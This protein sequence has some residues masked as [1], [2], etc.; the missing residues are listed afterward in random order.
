MGESI[1]LQDQSGSPLTVS[2]NGSFAMTVPVA[3]GMTYGV[4]VLTA[5]SS[6]I[7]QTCTVSN[8]GGTMGAANVTNVAV[9]CDML[10][11]YPFTGNANDASGYGNNGVVANASLGSDSKGNANS[12][13]SFAGSGDIQVVMP[14]GFLPSGD[15][16]RTLTAWIEPTQNTGEWGVVYYGTG[17]CSGLMFGIGD[18]SNTQA[19]FWGG[20]DDD[21]TSLTLPVN[22]WSFVALVYSQSTPGSF[23]MYVNGS[24]LTGSIGQLSTPVQSTLVMGA[25]LINGAYFHGSIDSVRVY[26]HALTGP[27]VNSIYTSN[28]P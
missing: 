22:T 15:A 26:G 21:V 7:A 10:A 8:G 18:Q 16:S 13:Y 2:A 9:Q 12:A 27:E 4:T 28:A 20:C 25:D 24:S 19:T 3:V 11:Y 14:S 1:V 6:P 23:T 17:N 5:P